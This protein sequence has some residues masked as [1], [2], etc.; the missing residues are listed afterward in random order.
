MSNSGVPI[1]FRLSTYTTIIS[2][3]VFYFLIKMHGHIGLLAYPSFNKYSLRRL[4]HMCLD[5]FN[6]Y[7][8]LC[9]LIEHILRGFVFTTS[10]NV[11]PSGIFIYMSL[12]MD[13]YRYVV[14][15]S[16][17]FISSPLETAKLIKKTESDCIHHRSIC[18]LVVNTRPLREPLCY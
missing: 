14:M 5:C 2:N 8:D 13:P 7:R 17:R 1:R 4:Y 15:T 18:F 12:S 9:N 11:N 6:L 16:M 3:P 10:G